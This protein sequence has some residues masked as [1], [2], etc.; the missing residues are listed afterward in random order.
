M[1]LSHQAILWPM[2]VK[3]GSRLAKED[4][5]L[6]IVYCKKPVLPGD[7]GRLNNP[8]DRHR[9]HHATPGQLKPPKPHQG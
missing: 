1:T 5:E 2:V 4:V 8:T 6:W 3:L 9:K 7:A